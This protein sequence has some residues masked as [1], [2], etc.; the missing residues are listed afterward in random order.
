[1]PKQLTLKQEISIVEKYFSE[2]TPKS[3]KQYKE[4]TATFKE[5]L[6]K[7][8]IKQAKICAIL[9]FTPVTLFR[10]FNSNIWPYQQETTNFLRITKATDAAV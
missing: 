9:D 3:E 10:R 5:R 7:S 4:L 6:K 1:M 8:G 2:P